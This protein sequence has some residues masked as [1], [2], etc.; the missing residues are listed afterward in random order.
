M[1]RI[2]YQSSSFYLPL[3]TCH[4]VLFGYLI[5]NSGSK[6]SPYYENFFSS[7][8]T[9]EYLVEHLSLSLSLYL[10]TVWNEE[11]RLMDFHGP[12]GEGISAH[13]YRC[14]ESFTEKLKQNVFTRKRKCDFTSPS[15]K[16]YQVKLNMKLTLGQLLFAH[17]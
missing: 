17:F 7:L 3:M 11:L 2:P 9:C 15:I 8:P 5:F 1:A 13:Q 16:I 4:M 12:G 14:G 6:A 10:I